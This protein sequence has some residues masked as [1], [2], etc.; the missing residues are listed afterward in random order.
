MHFSVLTH[1]DDTIKELALVQEI[2]QG[3]RDYYQIEKRY[4][5]KKGD[6]IWVELSL[7]MRL[8]RG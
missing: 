7:S 2:V 5:T 8:G 3:K 4:K 1:P 6:F